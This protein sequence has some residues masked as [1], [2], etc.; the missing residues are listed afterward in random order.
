VLA[1]FSRLLTGARFTVRELL[2]LAAAPDRDERSEEHLKIIFEWYH[3][4]ALARIRGFLAT[5]ATILAGFLVAALNEKS[6][7]QGWHVFAGSLVIWCLVLMAMWANSH[8]S[9]L[10]REYVAAVRL[11]RV[12]QTDF[13]IQLA[14]YFAETG[15]PDVS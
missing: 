15:G 10:Q 11:L 5:A 8:L 9:H 3:S 4:R 2:E 1:F 12:L 6:D 7:I 13:R 14:T